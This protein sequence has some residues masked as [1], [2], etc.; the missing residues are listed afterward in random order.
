MSETS[1]PLERPCL[2]PGLAA[3]PDEDTPGYVVVWDQL[4]ISPAPLRIP[5]GVFEVLPLFNGSRTLRDIQLETMR[6]AGGLLLPL[7]T[8]AELVERLDAALFLDSPR[9][10]EY[11]AGPVR[12]PAC[13]GC[14]PAEPEK[15]RR[16][17]RS[18]FVTKGGPGIPSEPKADARL[19][20]VLLPHIDYARGHVSYAWGVK[21][22]FERCPASIFVVVGTSHYSSNRFTLTRKNFKTP[23]GVVPTDQEFGDRLEKHYGDGLYDDL[24][25]HYPEHSIELEVVWLQLMYEN[26]RPVKIVPL[27]VGPFRD[28]VD[29][30]I[31]P[32]ERSDIRRMID[33]LQKTEDE[34]PEPVC[35]IISGDLAHIGPKFGDPRPVAEPNLAHSR[36]QDQVL[37]DKAGAADADGYFRHVVA[38][39]DQRRICGLPPTYVVL[40]AARPSSGR[41][42]H[43]NQYV[44]PQGHE[45]VSFASMVFER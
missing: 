6:A 8:F 45:S 12:E 31:D 14:Y 34:T 43:Y 26:V 1:A 33:A 44:H 17:L 22:I 27:L 30:N 19:R 23:L 5:R 9:F 10:D 28:C 24:Y 16:Q 20:A 29:L 35:Y 25:A 40:E 13:L 38:E 39:N 21:E 4:R 18:Y 42:L 7:D 3:I 41:L 37:L 11:L 36:L 2:R 15:L 32:R